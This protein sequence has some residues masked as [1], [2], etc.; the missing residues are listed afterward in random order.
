MTCSGQWNVKGNDMTKGMKST[1][2]IQLT[3]LCFFHH[4]CWSQEK[5]KRLMEQDCLTRSSPDQLTLSQF[6][7]A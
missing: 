4:T 7:E 5:E 1:C 2:T 6:T 3:L